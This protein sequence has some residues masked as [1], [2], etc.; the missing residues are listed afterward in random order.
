MVLINKKF[1]EEQLLLESFFAKMRI[2]CPL[3][4]VVQ[5]GNLYASL[6]AESTRLQ[7][8]L[9]ALSNFTTSI[10]IVCR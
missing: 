1:N 4:K 6:I 2:A 5:V 3:Y 8:S 10:Y 9:L 7:T